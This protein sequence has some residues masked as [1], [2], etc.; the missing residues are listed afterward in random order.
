MH[1]ILF[2]F[3]SKYITLTEE[4]K[5]ALISLDIFYTLKKGT[6]LLH[7]G[8]KSKE[9]FFVLNGCIRKYYIIDGEEK[10][11]AFYTELEAITPHCVI[12][13]TTSEY[14]IACVEDSI[15]LI[16]NE[17]MGEEI[18]SKFP[19]FEIMCRMFSEEL[20]AKQQIDF[21]DFKT[22]SPAKYDKLTIAEII[23]GEQ[24]KLDLKAH[25]EGKT[26]YPTFIN[27]CATFGIEKWN[28]CMDKMTCTYFDKAGNVILVENIPQL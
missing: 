24:F 17:E 9:S 27:M 18:N 19:K 26:D 1:N 21:D 7:E 2:E 25:Q 6:V 12:N 11:T 4:E 28:V 13:N 15:V 23:N 5:S 22:S 14:F 3:I 8:Q 16:S 20:L 10:T